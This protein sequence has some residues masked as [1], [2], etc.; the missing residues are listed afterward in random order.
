MTESAG[1]FIENS[2]L[3]E[4][5]WQCHTSIVSLA[6]HR[7]EQ[8]KDRSQYWD[9]LPVREFNNRAMMAKSSLS[10]ISWLNIRASETMS[11]AR[12]AIW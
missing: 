11:F 5:S 4:Q 7:V 10:P 8:S 1:L 9:E 3:S 6:A 12:W 2:F